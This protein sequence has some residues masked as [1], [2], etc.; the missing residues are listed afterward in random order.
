VCLWSIS[1][2]FP[3]ARGCRLTLFH[4]TFSDPSTKPLRHRDY[5]PHS[6]SSISHTHTQCPTFRT[7]PLLEAEYPLAVAEVATATEVAVVE[8]ADPMPTAQTS[9]PLMKVKLAR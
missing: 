8:T 6:I 5:L 9:H 3:L 1:G 7:D 4:P 2:A